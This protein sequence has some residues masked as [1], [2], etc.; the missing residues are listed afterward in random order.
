M[1]ETRKHLRHC[2]K[3]QGKAVYQELDGLK[4]KNPSEVKPSMQCIDVIHALFEF[5]IQGAFHYV[6][7]C[8][9]FPFWHH[10]GSSSLLN[11]PQGDEE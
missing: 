2:Q 7:L 3:R 9:L 8:V 11:I 10:G 1:S 6:K 5:A 4:L